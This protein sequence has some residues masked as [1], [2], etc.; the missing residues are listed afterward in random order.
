MSQQSYYIGLMTGTSLDGIDAALI[1]FSGPAPTL[2]AAQGQALPAELR[3]LLLALQTPGP[4]EIDLAAHAGNLLADCYAEAVLALLLRAGLDPHQVAA[5]G[6]HGQTVRHRPERG[7]TV[8]L[9]N[10]ARLAELTGISVVGDFRSRDV[11]AGG[12]GAPLVPACH[13]ALFADPL[14]HRVIVNIGGIAN[15]TDLPPGGEATGF[16]TGPGN[17]LLDLWVEQHR[18]QRFDS[19]GAWAAGG[20]VL[21]DLL[22]LLLAEP[23]FALP[24]P[25]STGRDLFHA[26]WLTRRLLGRNDAPQDV[27]ATLVALTAHSVAEAILL[28]APQVDEVYVCGGGVHNAQLLQQLA[29]ALPGIPLA[30]TAAL[31]MDPDWVEAYAFAWLAWRCLAGRPGNLPQ[32]TGAKGPRLLGAIWQA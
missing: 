1:D 12:Q 31:G 16:D 14:R 20:Q 4:D 19:G 3:R 15:L 32:A 9:G 26:Q 29:Q 23:Y 7:Y 30:S 18:G 28:Q 2:L 10:N 11:A 25:K 22:A 8:Q 17:V 13:Q 27:Q 24:A 5:I 6:N 21:P